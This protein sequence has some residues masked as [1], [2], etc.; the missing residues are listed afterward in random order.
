MNATTGSVRARIATIAP[1]L[2]RAV[3]VA[4]LT[5]VSQ[6]FAATA[7]F[8]AV[9]ELPVSDYAVYVLA[10]S[11][12]SA[13][14]V[15]SQSGI[16]LGVTKLLGESRDL[17]RDAPAVIGGTLRLHRW[18][19]ATASLLV[20]AI[21]VR[22]L[23]DHDVAAALALTLAL[24][25]VLQAAADSTGQLLSIPL[26]FVGRQIRVATVAFAAASVRLVAF[27]ALLASGWA[28][29]L[30]LVALNTAISAG[31]AAWFLRHP[32]AAQGWRTA[33]IEPRVRGGLNQAV[34]HNWFS[35]LGYVIQSNA[36]LWSLAAVGTT[37]A[38]AS[39][40]AF[41]RLAQ[42][43]MPFTVLATLYLVP[44]F[45]TRK[46]RGAAFWL[47]CVAVGSAPAAALLVVSLAAPESLLWLIGANY[48]GLEREAM[49]FCA[50]T[51]VTSVASVA[52]TLLAS[53][54][55]GRWNA[56]VVPLYVAAFAAAASVLDL[57]TL[58]GAVALQLAMTLPMFAVT[59]A[60][61]AEAARAAWGAPHTSTSGPR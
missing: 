14:L 36:A 51:L 6:L 44:Y 32:S 29:A 31:S 18:L 58:T 27:G 41:A 56:A 40:G 2:A 17:A 52:W 24:L 11:A 38:T 43:L 49:L 34:R 13:T 39:L 48:A 15:V 21:L 55:W 28:S 7:G 37:A 16:L 59:A 3:P 47:A 45:V 53:A 26:T 23:L 60:N 22:Q 4:L 5:G 30:G 57:S 46:A 12:A 50:A 19:P 35:S 25:A 54:G 9:R 1:R 10:V 61:A 33:A 42:L 8:L 20:G